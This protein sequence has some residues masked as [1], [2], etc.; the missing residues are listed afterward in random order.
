ME[1][2]TLAPRPFEDGSGWY[3]EAKWVGRDP[4]RLGRFDTYA[5]A[6][7]W[8]ALESAVYFVLRELRL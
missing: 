5:A 2:P 7:E 6:R 8:I 4:E 3:V 1:I